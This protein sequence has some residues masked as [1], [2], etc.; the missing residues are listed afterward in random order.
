MKII[1]K[2][3]NKKIFKNIKTYII[4]LLYYFIL[5]N[6]FLYLIT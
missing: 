6:L 4:I 2:K 1:K 5:L 3:F